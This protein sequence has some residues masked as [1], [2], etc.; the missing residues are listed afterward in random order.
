MRLT[1]QTRNAVRVLIYCAQHNEEVY[2]IGDIAR[3]CNITEFN[4]FKLIPILVQG[5]FLITIRG[6]YGGV[7]LAMQPEEISVGAVVRATEQSFAEQ[8][9]NS[10]KKKPV[11]SD[12]NSELFQGMMAQAFE[13]FIETLDTH[14]IADFLNGKPLEG[15]L[16]TPPSKKN[17][18]VKND[19]KHSPDTPLNT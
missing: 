13:T 12:D 9:A 15:T 4:A 19:P 6:R 18:P 7:K 17:A 11:Q 3:A 1:Q 14:T 10:S 5:K 16:K 2:R 8:E